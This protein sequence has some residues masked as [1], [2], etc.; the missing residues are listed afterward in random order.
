MKW[1]THREKWMN[2]KHKNLT[3]VHCP[4]LWSRSP[5]LETGHLLHLK[6]TPPFASFPSH[7]PNNYHLDAN[8]HWL[9]LSFLNLEYVEPLMVPSCLSSFIEH[10]FSSV[11]LCVA[12]NCSI[13]SR[14]TPQYNYP[15]HCWWTFE[16]FS[17]FCYC[18]WI[19]MSSF[20]YVLSAHKYVLQLG[21]YRGWNCW[22]IAY[23]M[24]STQWDQTIFQWW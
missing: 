24:L 9:T 14:R 6:S 16:V 7:P 23:T 8:P 17:A 1:N 21:V 19:V 5:D 10:D 12:F 2:D 3:N 20:V 22:A 4:N 11:L 13:S 18:D 15:L